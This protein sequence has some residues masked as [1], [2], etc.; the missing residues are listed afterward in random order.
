MRH[1]PTFANLA[2]VFEMSESYF[3]KIYV[4]YAHKVETLPNW[5][6]PGE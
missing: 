2:Y 4:R 1:Y 5:Q 3:H 6:R